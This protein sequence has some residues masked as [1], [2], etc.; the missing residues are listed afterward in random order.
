MCLCSPTA[1]SAAPTPLA[2]GPVASLRV[3]AASPFVPIPSTPKGR[4]GTPKGTPTSTFSP[5]A[6]EKRK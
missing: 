2:R 6:S 1:K 3:G 5:V 4:A